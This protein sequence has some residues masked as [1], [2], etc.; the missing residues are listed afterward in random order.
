MRERRAAATRCNNVAPKLIRFVHGFAVDAFYR[1]QSMGERAF[2]AS[3]SRVCVERGERRETETAKQREE[4][5]LYVIFVTLSFLV[6][7]RIQLF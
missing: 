3:L 4:R 2:S 6:G 7:V 5:P 1:Y